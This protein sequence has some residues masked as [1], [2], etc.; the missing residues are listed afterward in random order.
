MGVCFAFLLRFQENSD[1]LM[2]G[3]QLVIHQVHP[4]DLSNK[5]ARRDARMPDG[6]D[7][8]IEA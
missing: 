7:E 3:M 1:N 6:A 2:F 4:H 8:K 5:H